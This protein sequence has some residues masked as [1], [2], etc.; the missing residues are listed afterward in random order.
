MSSTA[1]PTT[2]TS[3][4]A[5]SAPPPP[6]KTQPELLP[7]EED[8]EFE[9]FPVE[10]WEDKETYGAK[11]KASGGQ[12]AQTGI[13]S[14][15]EDNWDDDDVA[16]DFSVQLSLTRRA[17]GCQVDYSILALRARD[18]PCSPSA[19]DVL[20]LPLDRLNF[21]LLLRL[22]PNNPLPL[23]L[24]CFSNQPLF[25]SVQYRVVQFEVTFG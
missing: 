21:S 7:L 23:H 14:L 22:K 5:A 10:D 6:T 25:C 12:D 20:T 11:L 9:D 2:S 3:T 8:D 19:F 13:N 1:A 4:S 18:S 15:W 17:K 24:R 16:D